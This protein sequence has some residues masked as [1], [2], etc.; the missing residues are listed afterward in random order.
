MPNRVVWK[1]GM[2]VTAL[3]FQT[4]AEFLE[5]Q[6]Q[7]KFTYLYPNLWG[8][9][10]LALSEEALKLGKIAI[11]FARGSWSEKSI[12]F[13]F[14]HQDLDC[15]APLLLENP[16]P[17]QIVYLNRVPSLHT[18][19][20]KK[21]V[22]VL[23]ESFSHQEREL[24]L[25]PFSFVLSLEKIDQQALPVCRI[26][27]VQSEGELKLDPDFWGIWLNLQACHPLK[28]HLLDILELL[29]E[30]VP[31]LQTRKSLLELTLW[32][33][34]KRYQAILENINSQPSVHPLELFLCFRKMEAE[35]STYTTDRR[36][37]DSREAYH[38]HHLESSFLELIKNLK[39][40]LQRLSDQT[41]LALPLTL[42]DQGIWTASIPHS[43]FLTGHTFILCVF[44][45]LADQDLKHYLPTQLKVGPLEKIEVLLSRSL[46]GIPLEAL[47]RPPRQVPQQPKMIYFRL[48]TRHALW[49][50]L[51]NTLAIQIA[52][53]LPKLQLELW[54]FQE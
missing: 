30:K 14:S 31:L 51:Q 22:P 40:L 42:Q 54:T 25:Q 52:V 47:E 23:E 9:S 35:L 28:K 20:L 1:Q 6:I 43:A 26:Q 19:P 36:R 24:E 16:L 33:L 7:Q 39:K 46:S 11:V 48:D 15:P 38:H 37:P 3:H 41:A 8:L 29:H 27:A 12:P 53:E 13:E 50:E 17:G 5:K 2:S 10:H 4:Q 49:N 32:K 18:I 21:K 44:T 34:A 45:D